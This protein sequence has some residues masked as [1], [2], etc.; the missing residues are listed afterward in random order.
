VSGDH[1]FDLTT[2]GYKPYREREGAVF[3]HFGFNV[4]YGTEMKTYGTL[5]PKGRKAIFPIDLHWLQTLG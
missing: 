3:G 5:G 4:N 1:S 2:D